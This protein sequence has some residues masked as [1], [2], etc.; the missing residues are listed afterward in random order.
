[1]TES[2]KGSFPHVE[3]VDLYGDGILYEVAV[4]KRDDVGNFHFIRI[5]QLDSI[6]RGRLVKILQNRNANDYPLWDLMSNVTLGNGMNALEYFHQAVK[7]LTPQGSIMNPGAGKR[8]A[9]V[10]PA[11]QNQPEDNEA[12]VTEEK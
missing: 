9:A 10:R 11:A 5:D 2:V 3:W 4:M 8:G 7:I 6:D 12:S 1:M